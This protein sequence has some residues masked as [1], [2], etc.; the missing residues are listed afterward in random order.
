MTYLFAEIPDVYEAS[1]SLRN[2]NEYEPII[3]KTILF[4]HAYFQNILVEWNA[5]DKEICESNTLGEF[6]GK[7][8]VS[9]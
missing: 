9:S 8:L 2:P 3:C 4:S 7:L 1:S 5:L 6:K